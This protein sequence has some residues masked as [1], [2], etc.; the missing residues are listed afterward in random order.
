MTGADWLA[1]TDPQEMLEAVQGSGKASDR[2]FRLFAV[3]CYRRVWHLLLDRRSRDAVAVLERLA[4]GGVPRAEVEHALRGAC[5]AQF[6]AETYAGDAKSVARGLAAGYV[7]RAFAAPP[8]ATAGEARY[9]SRHAAVMT[10]GAAAQ[11]AAGRAEEGHCRLLRDIFGGLFR[12]PPPVAPAIMAWNGGLVRKLAQA[13]YDGRELPAGTLDLA[14]LAV[15]ADALEEGGCDQADLLSHLR[16]PGPHVRGCWV[17][18]L[19]LG[20]E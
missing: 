15:L 9:Y 12:P 11:A 17:I 16:G 6:E 2:Q 14:R 3:A 8:A 20:K 5:N 18:D 1:C 13:A 19:L 10:A 4:D 7:Y